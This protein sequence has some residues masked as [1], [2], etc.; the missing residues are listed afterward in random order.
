VEERFSEMAEKEPLLRLAISRGFKLD[1]D[2]NEIGD[3]DDSG[4][5]PHGNNITPSGETS[6]PPSAASNQL[7]NVF[8]NT[9]Q[10]GMKHTIII[11]RSPTGTFGFGLSSRDVTTKDNDQPIYIKSITTGGP[12]FIDGRLRLGD[13]LLEVN[14]ESVKGKTQSE[15]VNLLKSSGDQVTV[16]ISRQEQ[17][18]NQEEVTDDPSSLEMLPLVSSVGKTVMILDIPLTT[19]LAGLGVTV[20][21]RCNSKKQNSN[22]MGI[23]I[24]SIVPGGAAARVILFV[25]NV[26][27]GVLC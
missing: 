14:G 21:G 15:A 2:Q 24:K 13:R 16:V 3:A 8:T 7:S 26:V 5:P 12:A 6:S 10:I 22:D 18:E 4:E 9:R 1:L 23:Y 17:V 27:I 20:H 11:N 25:L 19:G